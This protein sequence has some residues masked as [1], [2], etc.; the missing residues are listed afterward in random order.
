MRERKANIIRKTKE[1]RIK[2]MLNIDGKGLFDIETGIDF[3]N[4]MLEVFTRHGLFD[5]K[6]K[7][8]SLDNDQH[9]LVE[10]IG[11]TLGDAF[12]KALG[13]MKG[14]TRA[15]YFV[16]PMDESLA[17][18]AIDICGRPYLRF[19]AEF[20]EKF[21]GNLKTE[22]VQEFFQGFVNNLQASLHIRLSYGR[23]DHHKIEA[24]FKG[25]GK[26]LAI[27][28]STNPK[29]KETFPSTKGLL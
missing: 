23:T 5:L 3:L 2:V 4:H 10:D 17:I 28:C 22:L 7:A 9:H 1:T 15:G 21:V 16:M 11:I 26:A 12:K 13:D 19:D 24:I 27:A 20:K 14:I 6:L 18:L 8:E 29:A 25:F